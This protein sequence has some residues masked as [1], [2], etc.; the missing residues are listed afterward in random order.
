MDE[1]Q[2]L[3]STDPQVMLEFLR[4]SG[5]L[6]ERK[7]RMFAVACCRS[8]WL[9]LTVSTKGAVEV[10]E[11]FVEGQA[12]EQEFRVHVFLQA[13]QSSNPER[14]LLLGLAYHPGTIWN[15][16]HAT[17][18]RRLVAACAEA[19]GSAFTASMHKKQA[20][21]LRDLLRNPFRLPPLLPPSILTWNDG[22]IVKLATAAYDEHILPSGHLDNVRLAILA[23]A[24]EEAGCH[25]AEI[26]GHLRQPGLIHVRGC[27]ALDCVLGRERTRG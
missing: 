27:W 17:A 14:D 7:A 2:W 12:G 22:C 10:V 25:D 19:K 16:D 6:S 8:V 5:K 26:L 9:S 1:L 15:P 13:A 4:D 20:A 21:L 3:T 24:L 11:R 23:D 18:I